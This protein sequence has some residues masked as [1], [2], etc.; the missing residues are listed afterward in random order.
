MIRNIV[1]V[2]RGTLIG[3]A[4][5]LLV[6]PLLTRLYDPSDFG[7]FQLY[8]SAT[9]VLV[10]FIS[11]RF[12]VALLRAA[13]GRELHAT[14]ALCIVSTLATALG[15]TILWSILTAW[16][17]DLYSQFPVPPS[18]VGI[19][20][21]LIGSFQFLGFLVT[22]EQMYDTSSNSKVVQAGTYA[23]MATALGVFR[24]SLGL[25]LADV[26]ARLV[27]IFYLLYR[28]RH[29]GLSGLKAVTRRDMVKAAVKFREFPL[30]TVFGGII[31]SSGAVLTPIMI[32][33]QFSPEVSGQFSLVERAVSLPIAMVVGAISQVYTANFA[34]AVRDNPSELP[35]Q[36]HSLLQVLVSVGIV[37]AIV[38]FLVAPFLFTFVFGKEWA[39]AGELARIMIPVY[40][41]TFVYGGVNMTL[42][43]LGRQMIQTLWETFRLL[44]MIV[45]WAFV[46]TPEM[47]V[48]TVVAIHAA[49]LGGMFLL[50]LALAEY[51]VRRGPTKVALENA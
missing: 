48:Q 10:V 46:V 16:R 34:K 3:Q 49:L 29:S 41:V 14:L 17:P 42:M 40:F 33:A 27:G 25:I 2:M 12:E 19:A 43:L 26:L 5:G 51:G 11:L 37:P 50:F 15:L 38:A 8:Q 32:Y 13:V 4:V 36:Y 21:I 20:A 31:N 1:T 6:L 45:L 18:I 35:G 28:M 22:R 24:V 30:V 39:L 7:L 47:P 9:L 23:A 44:G